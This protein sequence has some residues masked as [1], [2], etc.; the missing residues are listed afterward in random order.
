[1][2]T[3]DYLG[4]DTTTTNWLEV[5]GDRVTEKRDKT[6]GGTTDWSYAVDLS[7][8]DDLV[9]AGS[10]TDGGGG[11]N[12]ETVSINKQ[13]DGTTTISAGSESVSITDG[14]SAPI[15]LS[16]SESS[17]SVSHDGDRIDSWTLSYDEVTQTKNPS[18]TIAGST[19][20]HTGLLGP[21]ETVTESVDLSTGSQSG[22]IS[23]SGPVDVSASWT[24]V[25][26]TRDPVVELNG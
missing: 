1:M 9:S 10:S 13:Y 6:G 12:L 23:V 25:S 14:G 16:G 8:G 17:V 26:R 11:A 19:V 21:G 18:V 3:D 22:H 24:E 5:N 2:V 20:A 15:D 4:S 7:P